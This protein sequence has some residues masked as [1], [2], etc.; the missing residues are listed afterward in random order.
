MTNMTNFSYSFNHYTI[1]CITCDYI[2]ARIHENGEHWTDQHGQNEFLFIH[3][4]RLFLIYTVFSVHVWLLGYHG[5]YCEEEY[6]ECLS[7][8]C[9]NFATCRDLINAYE[10]ICPPQ[11][12]GTNM[13]MVECEILQWFY[14]KAN[15]CRSALPNS[16][17]ACVCEQVETVKSTKI[18]VWK[19]TATTEAIVTVLDLMLPVFVH[20]DTWVRT[21]IIIIFTLRGL[22][23]HKIWWPLINV[24]TL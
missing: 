7:A 8:P 18:H 21:D 3:H 4:C 6:N 17:Y 19:C 15:V 22:L 20:L 13:Y 16:V 5:L 10:C 14:L 2:Q 24:Q 12:E 9:Q 23:G 11:Y 1:F